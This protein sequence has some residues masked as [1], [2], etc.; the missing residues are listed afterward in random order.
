M[1]QE[2]LKGARLGIFVF[3][4]TVLIVLSIFL[5][6]SKEQLFQDT[7]FVKSYFDDVEGLKNGALVRLNGIN[8]GSVKDITITNDEKGTVEVVMKL[9]KSI[10]N[11]IRLDSKCYIETEGLVGNKI[12]TI[13]PGT[14]KFDKIKNGGV[15][16]SAK[17]TSLNDII[18]ETRAS[19]KNVNEFTY[20][21]ALV[22]K[23]INSG[24]GTL[25]KLLYDNSLYNSAVNVTQSADVTLSQL[26]GKLDVLT[27]TIVDLSKG[28]DNVIKGTNEAVDKVNLIIDNIQEGKGVLGTLLTDRSSYDSMKVVINNL[29]KTTE[30][31]RIAAYKFA[32]NMEALKHNWL[33]KGYFEERGYWD[34]EIFEIELNRKIDE[35]NRK[36]KELDEK[37]KELRM[38]EEKLEKEKKSEK[39]KSTN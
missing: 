12:V 37:I 32:E 21:L 6:G 7:Y 27:N 30:N 17:K 38:L 28:I 36:N 22:T 10:E 13:T 18:D 20:Q 4:G 15:I 29:V 2:S 9:S 31:T 11:F 16:K 35:L 24:R 25:G 19:I 8:I 3:L 1:A 39:S 26:T 14:S 33:F 23:Q 34:R 5:I